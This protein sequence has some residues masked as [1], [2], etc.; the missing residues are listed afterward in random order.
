[1]VSQPEWDAARAHAADRRKKPGRLGRHVNVFQGLVRDARTGGAYFATSRLNGRRTAAHRVLINMEATEGRAQRVTFPFNTF[2]AA[3]LTC[4]REIDPRTVIGA[5]NGPDEARALA[6][7]LAR[8]E[9]SIAA[10]VADLDEHG[11]SPALLKRLRDKENEQRKLTAALKE[12]QRKALH[13]LSASWDDC[14]SLAEAVANALDP[15]DARLRLRAALRRVVD[16]I[17]LLVV[18]RGRD[19]VAACQIRFKG[20]SQREYL[21]WHRPARANGKARRPGWWRVTSMRSLFGSAC[22]DPGGWAIGPAPWDL[23]AAEGVER[24]EGM[25]SVD[26]E[27]LEDLFQDCPRHPLT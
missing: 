5:D 3:V 1:V 14:Q 25:L 20:G 15:Q 27:T 24:T 18:P 12:A 19:R 4:L 16:V 23:S 26:D 8:V 2:E 22:Q 9:A 17:L 7:E 21:L 10:L 6:V 11:D 13:P